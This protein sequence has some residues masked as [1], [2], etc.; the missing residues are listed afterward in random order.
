MEYNHRIHVEFGERA[1]ARPPH[2]VIQDVGYKMKFLDQNARMKNSDWPMLASSLFY[3]GCATA[4]ITWSPA[5]ETIT[6]LIVVPMIAMA[7][8]GGIEIK[9]KRLQERVAALEKENSEL[10][11]G[12]PTSRCTSNSASAL[13]RSTS[14]SDL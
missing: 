10:R 1:D 9:I 14:S 5:G 4:F 3:I 8:Q 12:E 7:M 6:I 13:P 2:R 11:A